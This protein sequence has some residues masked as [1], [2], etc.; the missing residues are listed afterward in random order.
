[1]KILSIVG[2]RPQFVKAA[3]FR[4]YCYE[5]QIDEILLHTGQ[6]YDQEM[7][8]DIFK[9]L[10]VCM[11]N[12]SYSL[13]SRSHS[14]MTG[15]LLVFIEEQILKIK[16]DFVNV[17]GDTNS[18]L[19]GALA[20]SKLHVPILHI[21]AGL[22]SFNKKM[23]EEVN[24]VLTDHMSDYL[25]CPTLQAVENLAN[26]NIKNNVYHVGDI[27]LD[28]T[29]IFKDKFELPA[30]LKLN[31]SKKI[32]LMTVHRQENLKDKNTLLSIINYCEKLCDEYQIIFPVHPNTKNKLR[33]FSISTGRLM[34]VKP[35]K[36]IEMQA[37]LKKSS[38]VLTDSGGLQKEA[39]FHGSKCITLRKETEWVELIDAG[40]NSLWNEPLLSKKT[41]YISEYGDGTT[42]KKIIDM[43]SA[44]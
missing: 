12:I 37:L 2:A 35:M 16:P 10:N 30:N 21:E 22:R 8:T 17:Y 13:K 4:K 27:M 1:M 23:P 29:Q 6:H 24:R 40:W 19:A 31:N 36:Y 9:D 3:V 14:G 32:A 33:E 42:A 25:F 7:S 43:L 38:L 15:E 18:T 41:S 20:A 34:S 39:Y 5:N 28:A 44:Y 11:P 26:E